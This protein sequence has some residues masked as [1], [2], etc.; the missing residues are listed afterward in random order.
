VLKPTPYGDLEAWQTFCAVNSKLTAYFESCHSVYR[1]LREHGETRQT[2]L[3]SWQNLN[4]I[5]LSQLHDI[6]DVDSRFE[7]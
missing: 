7:P 3:L 5:L 2:D 1:S 6:I 4:G